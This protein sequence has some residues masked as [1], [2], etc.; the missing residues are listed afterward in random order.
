MKIAYLTFAAALLFVSAQAAAATGSDQEKID[1][2]IEKDSQFVAIFVRAEDQMFNGAGDYERF[3][4]E[5]PPSAKRL[6][7]RKRVIKTLQKKA[8]SSFAK[9]R[10]KLERLVADGQI[11]NL[12]RYWIVNGFACE[13]TGEAAHALAEL[14][15]VG[16]VYQQHHAPQHRTPTNLSAKK[17]QLNLDLQRQLLKSYVDDSK[18]P[19]D[20]SKYKIP[21]NIKRVNAH[22]VWK[23][24]AE[25]DDAKKQGYTG[26]G[27]VV[28]VLDSGMMSIPALTSGLWRNSAESL[29]GNDDDGNGY[30]DDVFGYDFKRNVPYSVCASLPPHGTLC[31]GIIAGR[32]GGQADRPAVTGIAPRAKIMPL[33]GNGYFRAYE[34]AL[35][36]G[37]DVLSMSYTW[38]SRGLGHYRGLI[39]TAHEH[40]AAA[41]IVSVG[42]VGNYGR[43]HPEGSQIGTPKDIPCVIAA[44][45]MTEDGEIST[46]S[47]RGPVSWENVLF[48]DNSSQTPPSKPDV[49]G[50]FGGYPMWTR[51]DVWEGVKRKR[52]KVV[53]EDDAGYV[54]ATG[55]RGNSFSGPHV[56]GVAALMLEANPDLPVWHL[57]RLLESTCKD[58]ESAGRDV[59]TGAGLLQADKAVEAV[60]SFEP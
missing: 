26:R 50:C 52:L 37:A 16:Y 6:K 30:V 11:R 57:K 17:Q 51:V 15:S 35:L 48:F 55:P 7:L 42:G 40:L 43:S 21:W 49:T 60:L 2:Q 24:L 4:D 59:I 12:Q 27:V 44:A 18:S 32:P 3:C 34:Y 46:S 10:R 54:L 58:L 31:A 38:D 23:G 5:Q 9:M 25:G 45:G 19:F 41:G 14:E 22:K 33:I 56:A 20:S 29:N 39:R 47:S 36:N 53:D 28:A 8:K 1:S 13:A